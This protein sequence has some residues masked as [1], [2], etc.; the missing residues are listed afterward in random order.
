MIG[1]FFIL[2][3][4]DYFSSYY[5]SAYMEFHLFYC[6]YEAKYFSVLMLHFKFPIPYFSLRC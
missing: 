4:H 6:T 1:F 3:N 2:I 5:V